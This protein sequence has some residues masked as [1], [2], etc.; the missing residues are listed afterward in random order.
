M[1]IA[2]LLEVQVVL[3]VVAHLEAE[4]PVVVGVQVK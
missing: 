1:V 4:A 3:N 2:V